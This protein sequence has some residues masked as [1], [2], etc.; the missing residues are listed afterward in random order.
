MNSA[1]IHQNIVQV[2]GTGYY[3]VMEVLPPRA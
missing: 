2:K 1:T 3:I